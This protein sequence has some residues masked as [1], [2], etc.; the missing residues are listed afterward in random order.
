MTR[1]LAPTVATHID[2]LK[3]LMEI[4]QET[5]NSR[6]ASLQTLQN[7]FIQS[8]K[9]SHANM[10]KRFTDILSTQLDTLIEKALPRITA[11]MDEKINDY[12]CQSQKRSHPPSTTSS[13]ALSSTGLMHPMGHL[14]SPLPPHMAHPL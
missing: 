6:I 11:R 7:D 1:T 12:F 3:T 9:E 10:D 4:Q 2:E 14:P 13:P 5:F 8:Q